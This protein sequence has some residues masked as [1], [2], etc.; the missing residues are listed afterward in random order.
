M[1]TVAAVGI[2]FGLVLAMTGST[3]APAAAKQ[4]NHTKVPPDFFGTVPLLDPSAS[5]AQAMSAA[6]VESVR[7]QIYWGIAEPSPGVYDWSHYD[8]VIQNIASARLSPAAQFATSPSWISD[9]AQR[10]PIYSDSQVAAW[11]NF[12]SAFAR[13]YAR[14][15]SFWAEHPNL[16]YEPVRSWE[17][18]NEPNLYFTWGGPPNAGDYLRLLLVSKHAIEGVDPAARIVF[19]GLFPFPSPDFGVKAATFLKAFYAHPGARTSFDVLSV[20]PYSYTPADVVPAC[21]MFRKLLDRHRSR[22]TPLWITELGWS[23]S[24]NGWATTAYRT[25]ERRQAQYLTHSFDALIRARRR[26]RLQRVFWH[27]WRDSSDSNSVWI[28]QM[29]LLRANGSAK[30]SYYAYRRLARG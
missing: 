25:T 16:P 20:H 27:D 15:G 7:L 24:G 14:G 18:W 2:L 6:G 13:R 5:D 19:G 9:N 26:L 22:R 4:A 10:P 30:P 23:T 28:Y 17:I 3:A 8:S 29:G 1:R 11:T 12:L 21:R